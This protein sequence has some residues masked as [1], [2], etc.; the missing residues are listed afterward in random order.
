[1]GQQAGLDIGID[2]KV[3][4]QLQ[5][6]RDGLPGKGH[7]QLYPEGRGAEDEAAYRGRVIMRPGGGEH[8][9]DT[10]G[11]HDHVFLRDDVRR[12]VAGLGG[13]S[14]ARSGSHKNLSCGNDGI[15]AS[16]AQAGGLVARTSSM[17]R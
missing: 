9:S 2:E 12:L 10:L 7:I 6:K 4:A 1:M 3:A 14:L 13:G 5:A 17:G 16:V 8:R 11:Q 15:A